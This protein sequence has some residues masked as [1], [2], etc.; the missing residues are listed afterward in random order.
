MKIS[1]IEMTKRIRIE[2]GIP[3]AIVLWQ[4]IEDHKY[5]TGYLTHGP[6]MAILEKLQKTLWDIVNQQK[7]STIT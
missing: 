7:Q 2:I 4:I 3:E 5:E 6:E 1:D